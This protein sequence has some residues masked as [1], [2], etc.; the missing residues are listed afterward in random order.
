[1]LEA[2][3]EVSS[4]I[5]RT[6]RKDNALYLYSAFAAHRLIPYTDQSIRISYTFR[7]AFPTK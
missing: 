7:D 4:R 1:M 5:L 3:R 6:E 2:T